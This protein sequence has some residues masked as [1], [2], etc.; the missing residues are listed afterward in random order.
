MCGLESP[1]G[2]ILLLM[3]FSLFLR[4]AVYFMDHVSDVL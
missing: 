1:E 2:K 4:K 3:C